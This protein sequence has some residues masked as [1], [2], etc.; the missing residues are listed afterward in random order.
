M[1]FE[2][3][4]RTAI[5]A[6]HGRGGRGLPMLLL[7]A[8]AVL[9]APGLLPAPA[10]AQSAEQVQYWDNDEITIAIQPDGTFDVTERLGYVFQSGTF[11]GSFRDI[12]PSRLTGIS[13]VSVSEDGVG[14]YRQDNTPLDLPEG[15]F[16]PPRTY[17]V[18][19]NN[20]QR[21]IIWFYGRLNAPARKTMVVKYRV[22]GG[23]RFYPD[24]DQ[25]RWDAL[26][27][28]RTGRIE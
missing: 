24:V 7:L 5:R 10:A 8:L 17:Q 27:P 21:R 11:N 19:D 3:S 25:L 28:K 13:N 2:A 22:S 26:M 20:G 15:K 6:A 9:L 23:L 14:A 1:K 4:T 18:I 16:G 12:D